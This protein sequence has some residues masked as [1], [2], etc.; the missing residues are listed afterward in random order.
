MEL[1]RGVC[2]G[3][4]QPGNV[5]EVLWF[6]GPWTFIY[7]RTCAACGWIHWAPAAPRIS[8]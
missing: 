5:I 1:Q 2:P 6:S 7:Q 8:A 4:Y 3:C